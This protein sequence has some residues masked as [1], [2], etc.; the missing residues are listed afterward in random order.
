[1]ASSSTGAWPP[2]PLYQ[3]LNKDKREIRLLKI[4]PITSDNKVNC[5]LHTVLLTP[6]LYYTCIS[7]VWGDPKA[8]EEIIV[9]GTPTKVTVNLAT[10]LRHLKKHWTDIE[11]KSDPELDTSKFRLWADAICINQKD[12]IERLH[13]VNMM[14]DIYSSAAMVLAWLS[15]NDEDVSEAF[16][17]FERIVHIAEGQVGHV[18]FTSLTETELYDVGVT[19]FLRDSSL[20]SWL[21]VPDTDP[22]GLREG[23]LKGSKSLE[24]I[25]QFAE[26]KFWKRVWIHQEV[27]LARELYLLSPSRILQHSQCF[28]ALFGLEVYMQKLADTNP[29]SAQ[30]LQIRTLKFLSSGILEILMTRFKFQGIAGLPGIDM[31][32]LNLYLSLASEATKDLD[33]IYGLIAVTKAPIVPDYNKSI[34]DVTLEFMAWAVP[35][36]KSIHKKAKKMNLE[37]LLKD[38]WRYEISNILNSHAAGLSDFGRLHHLPSWA[39]VFPKAERRKAIVRDPTERRSAF[40]TVP[41]LSSGLPIA[42]INDSLWIKGIKA[43][44]VKTVYDKPVSTGLLTH[45]LQECIMSFTKSPQDM[46]PNGKSVLEVLCCTLLRKESYENYAFDAGLCVGFWLY[47]DGKIPVDKFRRQWCQKPYV[48]TLISDWVQKAHAFE[49]YKLF[50]TEDGYI[51]TMADDV[52]P[53][54]VVCVLAGSNELAVL[55]S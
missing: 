38:E 52:Q 25:H 13:Q 5:K 17:A 1:M 20:L 22:D 37:A 9:D 32:R 50:T 36:W 34:R 47:R 23:M 51:G 54:D 43:Q 40:I 35:L 10:A 31:W 4:L 44:V 3:P 28:I 39:P 45:G 21:I 30:R 41:E 6:D 26:L 48:A 16:D 19:A 42:V 49:G 53:G 15:S 24:A 29:E 46:Y 11:R 8:T 14:A 18:D 2:P 7:Y 27:V 33:Y 55:P 12:D